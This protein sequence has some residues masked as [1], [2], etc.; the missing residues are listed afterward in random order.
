MPFSLKSLR[1]PSYTGPVSD[2]FDGRRFF[3]P[4]GEMPAPLSA[5]LKWQFEGGREKWSGGVDH[6]LPL[7]RPP[8]RVDGDGAR[9]LAIGHASFLYQTGGL[10]ILVDPVFSERCPARFGPT[11]HNPPG[12]AFDDLPTIDV[13]CLT[14]SHYD[15]MDRPTIER[16]HRAHRP[17]FVVPL[18]CDVLV[19]TWCEDAGVSSH[20][21][22]ERVVLN[23]RVAVTLDPTHHWSARG[24][25]DRR[26]TLWASFAFETPAG[27]LYHI[28]DTGFFGG[29]NYRAARARFGAPKLGVIPIGAYEPRGVM[30]PQHQN[31]DEAV[32]GALFLG[33]EL[34]LGSHWGT[35]QLTDEPAFDPPARL[36]RALERWNLAP[37]RFRPAPPGLVLD[38]PARIDAPMP[39]RLDA[40]PETTRP[41]RHEDD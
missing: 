2:H 29:A 12:V 17:R 36:G 19:R 22:F 28:G 8:P 3:N 18:G 4:G 37:T 33:A 30:R 27:L 10:N 21:W 11:R 7:D 9:V 16:L 24:I 25:L 39:P 26:M 5:I 35:F 23:D 13:V 38:L 31:P 1:N 14:H 34:S 20:D 15:H 41:S 32:R 6:A 40:R